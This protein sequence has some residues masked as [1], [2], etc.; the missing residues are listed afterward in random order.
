M[1][2]TATENAI[3]KTICNQNLKDFIDVYLSAT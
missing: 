3:N 1:G 2:K